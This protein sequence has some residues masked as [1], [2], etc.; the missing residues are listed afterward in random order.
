MATPLSA[1]TLERV[2]LSGD[3]TPLSPT[4]RLHYYHKVCEQLGLN[5]LSQPFAY[6][7]LNDKLR[8]YALRNA[9]DQL[10]A[11]RNISVS[12]VGREWKDSLYIVTSRA[13]L[14]CGR[15]DE[16]IGVVETKGLQGDALA[17]SLMKC[18]SKSKRRVTLSIVGLS[19]LDESE[20]ASI[21]GATPWQEPS[22]PAL[23]APEPQPAPVPQGAQQV[24][25]HPG[26]SQQQRR[27]LFA[28]AKNARVPDEGW[29]AYMVAVQG[30]D[31][32]RLLT[33]PQYEHLCEDLEN[34]AVAHWVEER[35]SLA[36]A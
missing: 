12:I 15:T 8:L 19:L 28:L 26:I 7:R 29:R 25:P 34:G 21:P 16:A 20:V 23:P 6:L 11:R 24:D 4:E 18:E 9:T 1:Q 31:S 2:L 27:R 10:R 33:Q 5:P 14:P 22:A 3:L 36:A 32:T 13:T 35:A 17:N 30:T